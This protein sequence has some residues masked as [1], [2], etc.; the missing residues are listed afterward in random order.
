MRSATKSAIPRLTDHVSKLACVGHATQVA[1]MQQSCAGK[2]VWF[3]LTWLVF[4]G[5]QQSMR[6]GRQP[7]WRLPLLA[8]S[9]TLHGFWSSV[10]QR[11][12]TVP[13]LALPPACPPPRLQA[14]LRDLGR[15]A[16]EAGL[17]EGLELPMATATTGEGLRPPSPVL[18]PSRSRVFSCTN[19]AGARQHLGTLHSMLPGWQNLSPPQGGG[20]KL[21]P[22]VHHVPHPNVPFRLAPAV[23]EFKELVEWAELDAARCEAV[24]KMLKLSRS[25]EEA[26]EHAMK[27]RLGCALC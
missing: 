2:A 4:G 19:S 1:G 27:V 24:K 12:R 3:T 9:L 22:H 16:V 6:L 26:R 21:P 11:Q 18:P 10:H 7:L 8:T 20:S 5:A 14:K 23:G 15:A 17:Q 13:L 25:W